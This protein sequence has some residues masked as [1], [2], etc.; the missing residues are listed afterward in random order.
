MEQ[1]FT[2]APQETADSSP[3]LTALS[4][5]APHDAL[6]R[7]QRRSDD[8]EEAAEIENDKKA[9]LLH[10]VNELEKHPSDRLRLL[11]DAG[12]TAVGAAACGTA[13]MT[14]GASSLVTV[15]GISLFTVA[16]PIGLVIGAG[17]AGAAVFYGI[18]RLIHDGGKREAQMERLRQDYEKRVKEM[19]QAE[20]RA[21]VTED[22]RTRFIVS[23]RPLIEQGRIPADTARRL[24][25]AVESGKMPL[26]HAY[27][28]LAALAGDNG[29]AQNGDAQS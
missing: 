5:K 27:E 18:S 19:E 2:Q 4:D 21:R 3:G 25:A 24:I 6:A 26:S 11:G 15:A 13:A 10:L 12:I 8:P 16:A 23:M 29:D 22:D 14:L 1:I 17:V 9:E 28:H 20:R 7:W